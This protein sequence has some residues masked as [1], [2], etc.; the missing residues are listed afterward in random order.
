MRFLSS[1]EFSPDYRLISNV[2]PEPWL[3]HVSCWTPRRSV[4]TFSY[5]HM[6]NP[7]EAVLKLAVLL[8]V[9]YA[10]IFFIDISLIFLSEN[11]EVSRPQLP[12]SS[13]FLW[14]APFCLCHRSFHRVQ[15]PGNWH[16]P[17]S[18]QSSCCFY[19]LLQSPLHDWIT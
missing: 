10:G 1:A 14:R 18:H 13:S 5:V 17:V 7:C 8:H 9:K 3:L 15:S 6:R 12:F 11:L 19:Q 4:E 16:N 2:T